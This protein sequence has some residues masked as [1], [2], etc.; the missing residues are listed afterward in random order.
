MINKRNKKVNKYKFDWEDTIHGQIEI[1][2]EN[3]VEA[4]RLFREMSLEKRLAT[5]KTDTDKVT[6]H[7]KYVDNGLGDIH[8][9][10]E[11]SDTWKKIS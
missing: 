3:G 9:A 7:I 5:S 10:D 6:L 2:A 8:S 4:E 11:W 1:E